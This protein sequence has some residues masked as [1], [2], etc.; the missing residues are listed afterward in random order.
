MRITYH[1]RPI[2]EIR[3]LTRDDT[4]LAG[5]LEMLRDRG[6]IHLAESIDGR[7]KPLARRPGALQRFLEERGE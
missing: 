2:A 4:T 3:P 1:G 5:R 6:V 7:W